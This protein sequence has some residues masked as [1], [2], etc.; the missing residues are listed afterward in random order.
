[1]QLV[2]IYNANGVLRRVLL[3]LYSG[4]SNCERNVPLNSMGVKLSIDFH[5]SLLM[6]CERVEPVRQ[7]VVAAAT[8]NICSLHYEPSKRAH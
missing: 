3:M 2:V 7:R 5:Y 4:G 1:M 6:W 8:A